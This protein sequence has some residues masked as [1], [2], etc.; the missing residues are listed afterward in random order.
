MA[1][2]EPGARAGTGAGRVVQVRECRLHAQPCPLLRRKM[3]RSGRWCSA[4]TS[5]RLSVRRP[6]AAWKSK[7]QRRGRRVRS[8]SCSGGRRARSQSWVPVQFAGAQAGWGLRDD[9]GCINTSPGPTQWGVSPFPKRSGE[10]LG[11]LCRNHR[12]PH[13][14]RDTCGGGGDSV[15]LSGGRCGR[16]ACEP[17]GVASVPTLPQRPPPVPAQR[18]AT[19]LPELPAHS[20]RGDPGLRRCLP[21]GAGGGGRA[22]RP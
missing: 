16:R 10:C 6:S 12:P 4:S 21:G 8:P 15:G 3:P 1:L 7:W 22:G 18:P 20:A 19:R 14:S 13:G 2:G 17:G 11:F 9:S 5:C